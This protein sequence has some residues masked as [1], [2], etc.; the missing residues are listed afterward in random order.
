MLSLPKATHP[1]LQSPSLA[2]GAFSAPAQERAPH[3]IVHSTVESGS[4]SRLKTK[5]CQKVAEMAP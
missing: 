5:L 3:N 1:D 4:L 2:I